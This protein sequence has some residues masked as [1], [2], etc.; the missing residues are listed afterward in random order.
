MN[1]RSLRFRL[2]TWY[3]LWL[4]VILLV[5][6]TLLYF[7]LRHYLEV[8]LTDTQRHRAERIVQLVERVAA[9]PGG[10]LAGEI[11]TAFAPEASGRF[12]RVTRPDATV[13]Y[14]SGW[15]LDRSFDPAQI[16]PPRGRSESRREKL[17]DGTEM[18]IVTVASDV[19]QPPLFLSRWVSLW[20]PRSTNCAGC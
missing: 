10:N 11:T 3:A 17:G 1:P 16:S 2:V 12:V 13:L 15:P 4:A 19:N 5:A 14:Q 9:T 7:G 8:N 20:R 18:A 6:G